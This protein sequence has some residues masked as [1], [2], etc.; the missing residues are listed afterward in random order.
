MLLFM[1]PSDTKSSKIITIRQLHCTYYRDT[2]G[3]MFMGVISGV[4][5][6]TV[7]NI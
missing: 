1:I 4:K 3:E 6:E 2:T 5:A 7:L